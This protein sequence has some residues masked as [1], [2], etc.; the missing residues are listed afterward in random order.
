MGTKT[1][2]YAS[3]ADQSAK[4]VQQEKLRVSFEYIDWDTDEFFFHGMEKSYY[5]KF[6]DTITE[7]KKAK[8]KE[9][10]EQSYYALSPKSIFNTD[11]SIKSSF[12][13]SVMAKISDKLFIETK[14]AG[15]SD[16]EARMDADAKAKEMI[17]RAFEISLG[18]NHGR[19]HGYVW[20]N[21]FHVVWID[22]AHNLYP[23]SHGVTPH[24]GAATVRCFAPDEAIRL[25]DEIKKLIAENATLQA[26]YDELFEAFADS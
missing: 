11:S 25:Q 21:V 14:A 7:L 10:T 5:E 3:Y 22:P 4:S 2:R 9:I 19:I 6:F 12:P 8:E 20:N 16:A 13:Y 26:E 17:N 23:M 1:S 24:S 18:K 15:K